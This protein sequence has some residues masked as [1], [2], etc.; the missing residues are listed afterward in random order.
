M[1]AESE[2]SKLESD[3]PLSIPANRKLKV[4]I[5]EDSPEGCELNLREIRK[6]GYDPEWKCVESQAERLRSS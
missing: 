1:E 2:K 5:L 6:A 3:A 4:L